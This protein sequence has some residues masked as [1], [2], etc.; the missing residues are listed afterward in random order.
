MT[1][2]AD[3]ANA[4]Y[5]RFGGDAELAEIVEMFL[6][7]LPGRT[8][9]ILAQ[10]DASDWDGLRRSAHQLRGAAGSYGFDPITPR[11]A[12]VESALIQHEPEQQIREAVTALVD[13][14]R[15]ARSGATQPEDK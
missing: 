10:L 9:T 15:R 6:G 3:Q 13:L 5:S 4:L 8:A 12:R 7:E 14:C 2:I 11:A 1:Q